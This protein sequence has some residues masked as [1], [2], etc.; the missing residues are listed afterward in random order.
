[1]A[2]G[3]GKRGFNGTIRKHFAPQRPVVDGIRFDSR[4]EVI[5]Y[6]ELKLREQMGEI[7]DLVVHPKLPLVLNGRKIVPSG[8]ITL[9]FA[10]LERGAKVYEDAKP[11]GA[12]GKPLMDREAKIKIAICEAIHNIEVKLIAVRVR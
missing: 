3:F 10:Y 7:S 2:R 4:A 8:R 11:M 6:G 9:D 1:M 12:G 5:R